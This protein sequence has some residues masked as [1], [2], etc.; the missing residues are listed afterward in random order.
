M[1]SVFDKYYHTLRL[2]PGASLREI[3]LTWKLWAKKYHP[4][5]YL[6]GPARDEAEEIFKQISHA[7][8]ELRRWWHENDRP[9]PTEKKAEGPKEKTW[10]EKAY[11]EW[12]KHREQ[13]EAPPPPPPPPKKSAPEPPPKPSVP[14]K[15]FGPPPPVKA[16]NHQLYDIMDT[17]EAAFAL[18]SLLLWF[19]LLILPVLVPFALIAFFMLY[20]LHGAD[21]TA[22]LIIGLPLALFI[23]VPLWRMTAADRFIYQVQMHPILEPCFLSAS[24]AM[25]R[26]SAVIDNKSF[27]GQ[28]WELIFS[29]LVAQD[30]I[31]AKDW[32]C[33]FTHGDRK[34]RLLLKARVMQTEDPRLS[35][36]SIWFEID[37]AVDWRLPVADVLKATSEALRKG[38]IA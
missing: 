24:E 20:V 15:P 33:E 21:I 11:Q 4:D 19:A 38:V 2:P 14:P 7:R 17:R 18:P 34:Y 37:A 10:Q 29:D 16:W 13:E 30:D 5:Q 12:K 22:A 36:M 32:L 23:A 3:E 35:V 28:S 9:P 1:A 6:A 26:I 25:A 27:A 31:V 8:D